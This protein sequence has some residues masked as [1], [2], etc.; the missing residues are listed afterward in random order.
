M[1]MKR[2]RIFWLLLTTII[3]ML[4]MSAGTFAQHKH[5]QMGQKQTDEKGMSGMMDMSGMMQSPHHQL[6]HAYMQGMS[7]FATTVRDDAMKPGG[8]DVEVVRAAVSEIRHNFD[9][10]EALHQKQMPS[11]SAEMQSSMKA[12]MEQMDKDRS[13]VKDEVSAL[14]S[15][16]QAEK[17][18]AKEVAAHANAL[19][20]HL[21]MMSKMGS[22]KEM[23]M[24]MP[25]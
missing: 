2:K 25:M 7:A 17:P 21:D 10:M 9:A 24:K 3:A 23:Q 19:L 15:Y 12:M 1:N 13:M 11:M 14:E 4:V 16:V 20:K 8:M 18:D 6:M 5:A 22:N